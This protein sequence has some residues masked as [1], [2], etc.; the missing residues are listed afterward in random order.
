[1]LYPVR[2]GAGAV[3]LCAL[4]L[5]AATAAAQQPPAE[6]DD[7]E[8]PSAPAAPPAPPA[9]AP[10]TAPAAPAAPP[11]APAAAQE[12]E[13]DLELPAAPPAAAAPAPGTPAPAAPAVPTAPA[14]PS[15]PAAPAPAAASG[16]APAA[17]APPVPAVPAPSAAP[18]SEAAA[19][20]T[21]APAEPAAARPAIPT[22]NLELTA[23]SRPVPYG[24]LFSGF[25]QAELVHNQISEDQLEQSGAP[26]NRDE[27]AVRSARLRLDGG[28]DFTAYTL[29]L[30][31][32]TR[33]GPH[34][35]I[36][37]AEGS[38]L[39]RGESEGKGE[40]ATQPSRPPVLALTA[41]VTDLP[42]G[43]ELVESSRTRAFMERSAGSEAIFPTQM[44]TGLKLHGG[45]RFLR[46]AVAVV[47][48][49]PVEPGAPPRDRNAHKDI[50]GRFG[51][52]AALGDSVSLSGGTS[53][54]F[55]KGFHPG[56]VAVKDT[57]AWRDDNNDG[58]A[59]PNEIIGVP[60]AAATPSENFERWA[61]GLD[62]QL[63]V[64][65][66]IGATRFVAE[67]FVAQN[68]DRGRYRSDPVVTGYDLRQVSGYLG[69]TQ[70]LSP[71]ALVGFRVDAY[72]PNS[73]FFEER[74]GQLVPRSQHTLTLSPIVGL[75]LPQRARLLLQYDFIDDKLG[76][77]A[78]G[79]PA[80]ADN[81]LF[82]ARLQVD[83]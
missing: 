47:N 21:T 82:T 33:G 20:A 30:D 13:D 16:P 26:F 63:L 80:D 23:H 83:L 70:E 67:A 34:V 12:P 40:G 75:V 71:Y 28:H 73:D 72:D 81:D 31:A 78:V 35:G 11:A 60:G 14:V 5:L 38:L 19:A 76:R 22:G 69:L 17:P 42:F 3:P 37:R 10:R 55:G 68:H 36:R 9:G 1:M 62:L 57:A 2:R 18:P 65:S 61:I 79:N 66:P 25:L 56:S 4:M 53:F 74:R 64:K 46:Y 24:I 77:D 15:T 44:D 7:L 54:A 59:A 52:E 58:V 27:F 32:T 29:E 39:Y 49:E 50:V 41:G 43:F 8:I 51:A 6:E 45:Y 48:G